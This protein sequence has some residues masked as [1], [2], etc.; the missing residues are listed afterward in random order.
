MC[1]RQLEKT[2]QIHV[3]IKPADKAVVRV[4]AQRLGMTMSE[5]LY[6]LLFD[7]TYFKNEKQRAEGASQGVEG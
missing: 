7:N 6:K 4:V 2:A 3:R 5:Y 1:R